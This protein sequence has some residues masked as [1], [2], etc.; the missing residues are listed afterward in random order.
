[1][2]VVTADVFSA[3][4]AEAVCEPPL[5]VMVGASFASVTVMVNCLSKERPEPVPSVVRI[6]IV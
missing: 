3:T 2:T 5:L 6:V 4:E 1:M